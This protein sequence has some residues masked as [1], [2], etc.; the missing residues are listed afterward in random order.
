VLA[1]YLPEAEQEDQGKS[2][3]QSDSL[4]LVENLADQRCRIVMFGAHPNLFPGQ[5]RLVM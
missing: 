1:Q 4:D 2:K 3:A 5:K